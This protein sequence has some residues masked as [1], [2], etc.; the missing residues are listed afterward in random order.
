MDKIATYQQYV[1]DILHDYAQHKPANLPEVSHQVITD[2]EGHHYQLLRI[3]WQGQQFIYHVVFHFDIIDSRIWIQQNNTERLVAKEL[4]EKGVPKTD[5]V[6]GFQPA[7][8]RPLTEY[9]S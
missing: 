4:V 1:L 5:I 9:G 3:G 2:R 8:A 7:F 6:L